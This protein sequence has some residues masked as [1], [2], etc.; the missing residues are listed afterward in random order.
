[1]L[2]ALNIDLGIWLPNPRL[3]ADPDVRFK[4]VRFGYTM[5][6]IFGWYAEGDRYVFVADGGHWENLGLVELLRRRCRTILCIDA[7]G[8]E[9]GA[10]T[11]LRQAVELAYLELPEIVAAVDLESLDSIRPVDGALPA[12]LVATLEVTYK[13]PGATTY[14]GTI[15]YAKAQLASSL[16]VALRRFAKADRLFPNYSTGNQFLSNEQFANLVELGRVAGTHLADL[17]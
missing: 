5:K 15:H 16:D 12:G 1:L 10:Y 4:R 9:V 13:G 8:D 14:T 3:I 11:T 17:S 7:S 6:E 2:A